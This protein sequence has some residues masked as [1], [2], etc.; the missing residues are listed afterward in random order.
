MIHSRNTNVKA[1]ELSGDFRTAIEK[2][3]SCLSADVRNLSSLKATNPRL[4]V[5]GLDESY[6]NNSHFYVLL[7]NVN[8]LNCEL[9]TEEVKKR[10]GAST[11]I[12]FSDGKHSIMVPLPR[13]VQAEWIVDILQRL[14]VVVL[15]FAVILLLNWPHVFNNYVSW[16]WK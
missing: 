13:S 8:S 4:Q 2:L 7:K 1:S 9:A 3:H 15:I 6:V 16:M 10:I 11:A 5:G 12:V 14:G